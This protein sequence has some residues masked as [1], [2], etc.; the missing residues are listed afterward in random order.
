M[1]AAIARFDSR[2]INAVDRLN[3]LLDPHRDL[4]RIIEQPVG[5][6]QRCREIHLPVCRQNRVGVCIVG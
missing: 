2:Q 4:R 5:F 1:R 3:E 6:D